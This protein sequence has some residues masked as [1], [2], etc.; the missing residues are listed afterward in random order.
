MGTYKVNIALND[1]KQAV[2]SARDQQIISDTIPQFGGTGEGFTPPELL[3]GALGACQLITAKLYAKKFDVD[4][5][6][7]S[8]ELEGTSEKQDGAAD[9]IPEI[10][11]HFTVE[12]NSPEEKVREFFEFVEKNCLIGATLANQVK[13]TPAEITIHKPVSK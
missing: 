7:L 6:N 12:S 8:I 4:L 2:V 13:L 3:L 5:Q 10:K 11:F 9:F 1:Q